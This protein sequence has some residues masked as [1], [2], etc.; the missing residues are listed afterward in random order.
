MC[1]C[2]TDLVLGHDVEVVVIGGEGHVSEDRSIVHRLHRLILQSTRGAVNP[3][4]EKQRKDNRSYL[5][6]FNIIL[7][8]LA[9]DDITTVGEGAVPW[10][11]SGTFSHLNSTATE[12]NML[13]VLSQ[14]A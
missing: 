10:S 1:V 6:V 9:E 3:D 13:P 14:Q 5:N 8:E 4:L 12:H 11:G 7:I 2:V